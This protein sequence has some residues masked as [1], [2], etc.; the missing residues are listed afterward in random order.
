MAGREW[1]SGD[2]FSL[3][4][5]AAAPSLLYADWT[6]AIA[7]EFTN[8][9]NYRRRLLARPSYARALDEA[10]PFR[11]LFPPERPKKVGIETC[12]VGQLHRL[13]ERVQNHSLI[14]LFVFRTKQQR[15]TT[16]F[17]ASFGH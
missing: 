4:D 3:A 11:H 15:Q 10:R 9:R 5:C 6:Y 12:L 7:E 16:A 17:L 1:A 14:M 2:E 8:V 13:H